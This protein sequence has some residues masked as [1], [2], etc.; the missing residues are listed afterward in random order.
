MK[1]GI[2]SSISLA[3]VFLLAC[4]TTIGCGTDEK[5]FGHWEG[6]RGWKSLGIENEQAA[7][8]LAAINLDL[9]ADGTFVVTDF[10][11][12]FEGNWVQTGS[13]VDLR[14]LAVL[15]RSIEIQPDSVKKQAVF[16]VR[17]SEGK[18]FFKNA[19][20][21]GEFELKKQAKR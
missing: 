14:V 9:K 17:Y 19:T 18:I 4:G 8:G 11:I 3:A 6:D 16:T 13:G 20:D 21:S 5:L 12:P 7:R 10:G 2:V 15:K 1:T